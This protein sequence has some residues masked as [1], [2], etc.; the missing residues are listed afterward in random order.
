[1][2]KISAL[3]RFNAKREEESSFNN[4]RE[5]AITSK[6]IGDPP[7][8]PRRQSY[9]LIYLLIMTHQDLTRSIPGNCQASPPSGLREDAIT[10]NDTLSGRT[11]HVITVLQTRRG[12]RNNF[13]LKYMLI[14]RHNI[15]FVKI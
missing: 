1:M 6:V 5:D 7:P 11:S 8:P 12:I 4:S 10:S 14:R 3:Q 9:W 13:P 15:Y 2:V